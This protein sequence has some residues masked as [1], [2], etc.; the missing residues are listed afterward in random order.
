ML[1]AATGVSRRGFM[2][3]ARPNR[4][5]IMSVSHLPPSKPYAWKDANPSNKKAIP[6]ED[7][8]D[9]E[10]WRKEQEKA[11]TPDPFGMLSA[12]ERNAWVDDSINRHHNPT[13]TS[14]MG[15]RYGPKYPYNGAY[16]RYNVHDWPKMFPAIP[17]FSLS[18]RTVLACHPEIVRRESIGFIAVLFVAV[19]NNWLWATRDKQ[20]AQIKEYYLSRGSADYTKGVNFGRKISVNA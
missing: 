10:T 2:S 17:G 20:H 3:L 12:A 13:C 16:G 18:T 4:V 5:A 8:P 15:F 14:P 19:I 9:L 6:V 7:A 11:G 1:S